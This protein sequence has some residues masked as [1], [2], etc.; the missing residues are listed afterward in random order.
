MQDIKIRKRTKNSVVR[1]NYFQI[2]K[3]YLSTIAVLSLFISL[4]GNSGYAQLKLD[5]GLFWLNTDGS[6]RA[7]MVPQSEVDTKDVLSAM[8]PKKQAKKP[9][10]TMEKREAKYRP[11]IEKYFPEN[12]ELML[13]I[14]KAES[15]LNSNAINYNCYYDKAGNVHTT[16]PKGGYS[17]HC[18]KGHEKYAWSKDGCALQIN[19]IHGFDITTSEGC[20]Q[21]ARK[22]YDTQGLT[23]WVAYKNG[24]YKKYLSSI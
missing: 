24:S 4:L 15:S 18:K 16:R 12:S 9:V 7:K 8:Q 17:T 5:D 19:D 6:V 1:K 2:G 23:A 13:A 21:A 10:S 20:I 3:I 22:V 11:L 14:A